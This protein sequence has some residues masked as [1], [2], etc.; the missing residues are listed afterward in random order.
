MK[1]T[2]E[3][4]QFEHYK[5]LKSQKFV[6]KDLDYSILQQHIPYLEKISELSNCV[7]MIFDLFKCEHVFVSK[8][9]SMV[10][11]L[12]MKK[13]LGE[14]SYINERI[15]PDDFYELHEAGLYFLHF[16]FSLPVEKRKDGKLVNEY[17]IL[18]EKNEYLRVIEQQICL[19][20]DIHGN[21]WLALGIIDISPDQSIEAPFQSRLIN[22]K[23]GDFFVFPPYNKE[24][25]LTAREKEILQLIA[26]GL[27]SK[28]IADKLFI[29]VNT[30]NTDR[31]KILEKLNADNSFKAIKY[32]SKLG[33]I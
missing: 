4:L 5:L 22:V 25:M 30:V 12:D 26:K 18:N 15:H 9:I 13:S 17:R 1:R 27:I 2:I 32:A 7:V 10:L 8:N 31:Q 24:A 33:I 29:S 14:P 16:G 20:N 6:E 11:E 21:T 23:S 19:E 3:E 28:Q